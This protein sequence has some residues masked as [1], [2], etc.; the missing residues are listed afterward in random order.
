[1]ALLIDRR[2]GLLVADWGSGIV[3][4]IQADGQP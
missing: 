2:G 4:R 1:L 3:Y